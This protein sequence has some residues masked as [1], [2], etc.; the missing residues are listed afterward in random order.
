MIELVPFKP[1]DGAHLERQE[2]GHAEG[3]G[4]A[5]RQA[6]FGARQPQVAV[7]L[8]SEV[9]DENLHG[10]L[11]RREAGERCRGRVEEEQ[12]TGRVRAGVDR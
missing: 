6:D 1:A 7:A 4:V 11:R 8:Q 5:G 12:V 10:P 3:L 2:V 9:I